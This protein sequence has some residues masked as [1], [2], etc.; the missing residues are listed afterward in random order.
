MSYNDGMTK[1]RRDEKITIRLP[2][3]LLKA[4]E[5]EAERDRRS[6]ADVVVLALEDRFAKR[7]K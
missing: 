7:R 6:V 3:S 4:I 2:G 5:A 1:E